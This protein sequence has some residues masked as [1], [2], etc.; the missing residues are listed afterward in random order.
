MM[1][2]SNEI[3]VKEALERLSLPSF[4][5]DNERMAAYYIIM[6]Q[7]N[8]VQKVLAEKAVEQYPFGELSLART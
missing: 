3:K 8:S 1:E 2:M 4:F 6:E 5:E 7:G